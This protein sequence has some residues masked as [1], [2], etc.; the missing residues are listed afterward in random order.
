M[1]LQVQSGSASSARQAATQPVL[2]CLLGSFH[3]LGG[4]HPIVLRGGG[5]AESLLSAL[6][7]HA[8]QG[9]TRERLIESLWPDT[10]SALAGQSLNTLIYSLHRL[11]G[12]QLGGAPPVISAGGWY[13][14]NLDAGVG[15]DLACFEQLAATG[16]REWRLGEYD[17]AAASYQEALDLYRGD[18]S[19][20]SDVHGLVERERVRARYLNVLARLADYHFGAGDY[21]A[22]LDIV[23]QLLVVDGCREDAH[24]LAMRCY[25]RR[26]ERAQALRQF[27]LCES[28][29]AAEF[30]AA[31]EPA[32]R[33]L[34]DRVRLDPDGV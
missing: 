6:A 21:T 4:G 12:E 25:V 33:A 13:R 31:P 22:C 26:G 16:D 15:V 24:R 3:V 1:Q 27:R 30:D 19:A 18:L 20:G 2:I 32:T 17:A 7:L 9:L 11:L 34:F 28:I 5:K 10:D 14:L 29:L 8:Q 23:L